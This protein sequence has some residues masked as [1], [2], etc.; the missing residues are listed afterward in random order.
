MANQAFANY[1]KE[2][3]IDDVSTTEKPVPRG[4]CKYDKAPQWPRTP[5]GG[6]QGEERGTASDLCAYISAI[7]QHQLLSTPMDI[8]QSAH[9]GGMLFAMGK[10]TSV[11]QW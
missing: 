2:T 4:V 11:N 10:S 8:P 7:A 3:L 6:R 5:P 1:L 9:L